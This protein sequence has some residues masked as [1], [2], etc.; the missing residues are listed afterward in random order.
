MRKLCVRQ[1]FE[2]VEESRSC[3]PVGD[4]LWLPDSCLVCSFGFFS[5]GPV[6]LWKTLRR[7]QAGECDRYKP[8]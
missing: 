1:R 7:G 4:Y 8:D 3:L 5:L 2:R 6:S